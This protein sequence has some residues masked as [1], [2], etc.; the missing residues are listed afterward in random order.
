MRCFFVLLRS[1]LCIGLRFTLSAV[2]KQISSWATYLI[3]NFELL[4]REEPSQTLGAALRLKI[5]GFSRGIVSETLG[6]HPA[7]PYYKVGC[8]IN[9]VSGTYLQPYVQ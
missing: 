2:S 9:I 3:K 5:T 4:K 7:P 1:R 8:V 6:A